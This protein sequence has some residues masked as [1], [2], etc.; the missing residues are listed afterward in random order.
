MNRFP[1]LVLA[2]LLAFVSCQDIGTSYSGSSLGTFSY[3]AFDTLHTEV[4]R[5]TLILF[6]DDGK[7]SGHWSFSDGRSGDLEGTASNG[8][9]VL[10]LN[11]G[12]IDNNLFL[13]GTLSGTTFAG[14]WEQV[15]FPGVMARGT[16]LAIK[17]RN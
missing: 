9:L 13:L 1:A 5:G 14:V 10:N 17:M 7:V 11:P 15:G 2:V 12:T 6:R 4:A 8:D 3:K 16:F